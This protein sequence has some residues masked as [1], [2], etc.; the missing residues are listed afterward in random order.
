MA[1]SVLDQFSA[2]DLL[3]KSVVPILLTAGLEFDS[4]KRL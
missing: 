1:L 4:A 3:S 2:L